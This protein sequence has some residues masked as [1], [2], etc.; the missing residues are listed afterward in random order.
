MV[1][2]GWRERGFARQSVTMI[3]PMYRYWL[4]P[5]CWRRWPAVVRMG[6]AATACGISIWLATIPLLVWLPHRAW[7]SWDG[8]G[9]E[10]IYMAFL[11]LLSLLLI[12]AGSLAIAPERD[13]QTWESLVVTPL[14]VP[15]IVRAKLCCR[16]L[17]C[18]AFIALLLPFW[19]AWAFEVLSLNSAGPAETSSGLAAARM[20]IYLIWMGLRTVGHV[21]PCVSLGLL[22]SSFC[23]R[24]RTALTIACAAVAGYGL[25]LW[26]LSA[27]WP[28]GLSDPANE[29]CTRLFM[30]PFLPVEWDFY[31]PG[32]FVSSHWVA[33]AIS[34]AA[35]LIVLPLLCYALAVWRCKRFRA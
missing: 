16:L 30:W 27:V 14:G 20:T 18:S 32:S 28:T 29:I 12:L 2:V 10:L 9:A 22:I 3:D 7:E 23:R 6:I 15:R 35:W 1:R 25:L 11:I 8:L 19:I 13:R 34:D 17:R 5:S 21:L 31:E 4:Y 26:G 24:G 33:D